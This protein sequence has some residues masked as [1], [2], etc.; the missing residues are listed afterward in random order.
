MR[1]L[2]YT[3]TQQMEVRDTADATPLNGEVIVDIAHCGICGSDMHAYHGHDPRRVPPMIL[4]HEAVGIVRSGS[5]A[6]QRVAINPLLPCGTCAYC[7]RGDVHLCTTRDLVGIAHAGA[8]AEAVAVPEANLSVLPDHLD[9]ATASLAEPLACGVHGIRRGFE[10]FGR[11]PGD[12]RVA[13]LGGGAIGL[14][15]AKVYAHQGVKELWIAETNPL[16]RKQLETSIDAR[17]YDPREG[18]PEEVDLV[19]DAVGSGITR[20]A[21][22]AMVSHGGMIVHIGLQD[23]EP[24]L[25]TRRLTLQEIG[26]LGVYCYQPED[27]AASL[28]LLA[29]GHVT[30]DGWSEIR[31]L[32]EGPKS[33]SDIHD[34]NAPPKIILAME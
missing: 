34:G 6:G 21:A 4:G 5:M 10:S 2:F 15:A 25:D 33:F 23:S 17:A 14:L 16:R 24:G 9:F 13:V 18:G 26:F 22:S 7:T 1:A 27:F 32:S 3:G 30:R 29:D 28:S 31:P 20:A 8:Y 11:A 19:F 12:T